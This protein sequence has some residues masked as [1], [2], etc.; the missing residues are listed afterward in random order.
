[1]SADFYYLSRQSLSLNQVLT[2]ARLPMDTPRA[3]ALFWYNLS[4]SNP[5]PGIT[6]VRSGCSRTGLESMCAN[7]TPSQSY[8]SER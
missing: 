8:S 3:V 6:F 5:L 2:I 4:S 7:S 1:M